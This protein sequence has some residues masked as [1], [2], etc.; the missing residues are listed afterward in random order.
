MTL[1]S[2]FYYPRPT[3]CAAAI[4]SIVALLPALHP[5]VH[6]HESFNQHVVAAVTAQAPLHQSDD[7]CGF[8]TPTNMKEFKV[9]DFQECK[10]GR[11]QGLGFSGV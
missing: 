4:L 9:S 6:P 7:K 8:F 10:R 5:D 2:H 11:V 1:L 3:S